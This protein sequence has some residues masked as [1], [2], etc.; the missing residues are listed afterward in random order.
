[1]DICD[2]A[3]LQNEIAVAAALTQRKPE[4]AQDNHRCLNCNAEIPVGHR[5]C[6][7]ECRKDHEYRERFKR[8]GR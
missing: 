6:D 8:L 2:Q 5:Y 1:M 3:D 7:S 4:V